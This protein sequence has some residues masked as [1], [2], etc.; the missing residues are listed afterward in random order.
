M[1]RITLAVNEDLLA[2]PQLARDEVVMN[3]GAEGERNE[4][5]R[6][7]FVKAGPRKSW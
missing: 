7:A 6:P 4:T 3:V 1:R 5:S 2:V